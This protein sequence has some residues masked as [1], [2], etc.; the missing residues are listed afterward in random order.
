[1][2][3]R[4]KFEGNLTHGFFANLIHSPK[5]EAQNGRYFNVQP[6]PGTWSNLSDDRTTLMSWDPDSLGHW[7]DPGK[8]D[9]HFK[10]DW[11]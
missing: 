11:A 8:L 5:E 6:F 7:G 10:T 4:S 1:M 2:I 3:F 9:G